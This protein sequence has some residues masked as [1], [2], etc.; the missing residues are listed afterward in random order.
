MKILITGS[1]GMLGTALIAKLRGMGHEVIGLSR[2][3]QADVVMDLQ[4]ATFE[5]VNKMLIKISPDVVV[6]C[7]AVLKPKTP[8]EFLMNSS[9]IKNFYLSKKA[10]NIKF[11]IIG[12]IAEY[13]L[14]TDDVHKITE[15]TK[16]GK[17]NY[18]GE[19]KLAQT[20][21]S[22]DF[23]LQHQLDITVLRLSNLIAP[24]LPKTSLIGALFNQIKSKTD[25]VVHVPSL[26]CRRD[27]IDIRDVIDLLAKLVTNKTPN[28]LYVVG[29]GKTTSYGDVI[30]Q[31]NELLTGKRQRKLHITVDNVD[32]L[33]NTQELD[34]TL[35][36]SD[37][38]WQP[39]YTLADTLKWC[40]DE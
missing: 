17:L 6:H 13:G 5:Q 34:T 21:L 37:L 11:I 23:R 15:E 3:N 16:V 19:S 28:W 7:A 30:N 40:L 25:E 20:I 24:N 35:V 4:I 1:S 38:N 26:D 33:Y 22:S 31:F 36:S 39:A 29:S 2:D 14:V 12:S 27:F 9:A 10:K 8:S 32:E 18:Y